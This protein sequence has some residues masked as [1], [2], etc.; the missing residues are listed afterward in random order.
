VNTAR[1]FPRDARRN[2]PT[3]MIFTD[4]LDNIAEPNHGDAQQNVH[5][6]TPMTKAILTIFKEPSEDDS[7]N[8]RFNLFSLL[9][10]SCR[11]VVIL[12]M[13]GEAETSSAEEQLVEE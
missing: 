9:L 2:T 1:R 12:L 5:S 7:T 6:P 8:K 10:F 11:S 4:D 3:L 13:S